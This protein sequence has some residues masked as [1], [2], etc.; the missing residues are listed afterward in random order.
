MPNSFRM[1]KLFDERDM[2]SNVS[3]AFRNVTPTI[4]DCHMV[5][6]TIGG[7]DMHQDLEVRSKHQF[8]G[9]W[10]IKNGAGKAKT[11]E[12]VGETIIIFKSVKTEG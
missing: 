5:A 4:A 3:E 1:V 6:W 9:N 8:V 10:L 2:P 12:E 11:D 7:L